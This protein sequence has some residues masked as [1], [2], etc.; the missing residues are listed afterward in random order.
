MNESNEIAIEPILKKS[1]KRKS[2]NELEKLNE[3]ILNMFIRDEVLNA[4]G[5]RACT[6]Q[7]K[8]DERNLSKER[9]VMS[10]HEYFTNVSPAHL[11]EIQKKTV[12]VNLK[13]LKLDESDM[14]VSA[15]VFAVTGIIKKEPRTQF[16][17]QTKST[18]RKR[19]GP[20][21]PVA[22]TLRMHVNGEKSK[23]DDDSESESENEEDTEI[24]LSCD[25]KQT[26][27]IDA[28]DEVPVDDV[29]LI[30]QNKRKR[31]FNW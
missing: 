29:V 10:A 27:K 19:I 7:S 22:K 2:K 8:S 6:Q 14:P 23:Q 1:A 11:K 21:Q 20:V 15:S 17:G 26:S 16:Q 13:K 25:T 4:S 18:A 24:E 9:E 28:V 3:D 31:R 5:R 30:I 12:Q